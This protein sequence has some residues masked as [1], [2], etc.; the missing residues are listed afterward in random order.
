[1]PEKDE[2]VAQKAS[3]WQ[4]IKVVSVFLK[5]PVLSATRKKHG[6]SKYNIM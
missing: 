5:H 1:M 6:Q 3:K 2:N 4:G